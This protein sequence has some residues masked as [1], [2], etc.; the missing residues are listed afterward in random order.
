MQKRVI[1]ELTSLISYLTKYHSHF[2]NATR[3]IRDYI[4]NIQVVCI[5]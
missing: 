1:Q 3:L 2:N 4:N 5:F